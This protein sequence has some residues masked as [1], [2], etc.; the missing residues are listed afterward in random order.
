MMLNEYFFPIVIMKER[1]IGRIGYHFLI[2][3]RKCE[4]YRT[5]VTPHLQLTDIKDKIPILANMS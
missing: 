2:V 3:K 4:T 5:N 1:T